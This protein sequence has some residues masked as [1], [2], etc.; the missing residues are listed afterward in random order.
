[1]KLKSLTCASS[2]KLILMFKVSASVEYEIVLGH[3]WIAKSWVF[4]MGVAPVPL[5]L[6]IAA[7][8]MNWEKLSWE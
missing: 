6:Y 5:S 2:K 3:Y 7:I 8:A 1:M 4:E